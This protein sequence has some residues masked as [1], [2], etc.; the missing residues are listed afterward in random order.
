MVW[1]REDR[2]EIVSQTR[3]YMIDMNAQDMWTLG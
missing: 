3:P 1:I 2:H